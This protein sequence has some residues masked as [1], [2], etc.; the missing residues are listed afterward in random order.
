MP[1]REI[2][3]ETIAHKPPLEIL[4]AMAPDEAVRVPAEGLHSIAAI[5]AHMEFW[6]SWSLDRCDG[7]ALPIV[8]EAAMGWPEV[9]AEG[10]PALLARFEAGLMRAVALGQDPAR[11]TQP[12]MPPIEFP[13]LA[14]YTVHDALRDLPQ[15]RR[16]HGGISSWPQR[17]RGRGDSDRR[18]RSDRPRGTEGAEDLLRIAT[19]AQS[20]KDLQETRAPFERCVQTRV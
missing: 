20:S 11:L 13:P 1:M 9:S 18:L 12:V 3:L 6:Q 4:E 16:D 14:H 19:D 7:L 17:H 15:R 10:W 8:A 2:L 5:L